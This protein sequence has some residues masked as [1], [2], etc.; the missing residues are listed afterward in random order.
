M[1]EV[2]KHRETK[3]ASRTQGDNERKRER[4]VEAKRGKRQVEVMRHA[5]G[6]GN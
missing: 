1:D 4:K 2:R 3:R 5:K 6:R